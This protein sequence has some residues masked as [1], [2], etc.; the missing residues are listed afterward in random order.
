[1]WAGILLLGFAMAGMLMKFVRKF[2]LISVAIVVMILLVVEGISV[3]LDEG[4]VLYALLL[5]TAAFLWIVG[6][7]LIES[8]SAIGQKKYLVAVI[9]FLIAFGFLGSVFNVSVRIANEGKVPIVTSDA[10]F[11]ETL[12]DSDKYI[13]ATNNSKLLL[14]ADYQIFPH[15]AISLGDIMIGI[16][17]WLALLFIILWAIKRDSPPFISRKQKRFYNFILG[18]SSF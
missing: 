17:G 5:E 16:S 3:F 13:L 18:T 12:S 9:S 7:F 6:I 10:C 8:I 11:A 4:E 14:L 15:T 2:S 1:L